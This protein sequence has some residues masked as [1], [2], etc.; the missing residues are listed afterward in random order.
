MSEVLSIRIPK[1]LK[2]KMRKYSFVNWSE[3]I[4]R[5]IEERVKMLEL[6]EVLD[7]IE[8][9][10]RKRKVKVDSTILIREDR[11]KR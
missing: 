10:A 5:F 6:L 2:E 11:E 9:E 4:R 3:E 8:E 7:H 1:E